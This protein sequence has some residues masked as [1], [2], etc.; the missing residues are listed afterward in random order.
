MVIMM[1]NKK[2]KKYKILFIFLIAAIICSLLYIFINDNVKNNYII[3][4][5]KDISADVFK[6]SSLSSLKNENNYNN[7][8]KKEINNDYKNEIEKLK[9]TLHLNII[10]S[11]KELINASIIKRNVNY[12]YNTITINK[13]KNEDV[14]VGNAV[15][16]ENGLVGKVINVNNKSSDIKLLVALNEDNYISSKFEYE[17]NEYFGLL[18][19]YDIKKDELYLINVIGD[20]DKEKIKDINVVTSGLSDSFSSGLL[21]GK[22]KDIKKESFGISNTIILKPTVN[23]DDLD[24]VSVVKGK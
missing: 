8:V 24:I 12:W 18:S 5:L 21:V 15:I 4:N 19:K 20:F 22:I 14:R 3:S 11:D 13:G 2:R 16:N 10:N 6:I 1:K 23:F 9:Q 17:G 7:D